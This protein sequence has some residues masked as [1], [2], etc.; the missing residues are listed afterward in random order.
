MLST[1]PY[2]KAAARPLLPELT[3]LFREGHP[4]FSFSSLS[5]KVRWKTAE[6]N[7]SP[8]PKQAFYRPEALQE[9]FGE[10]SSYPERK[11]LGLDLGHTLISN[12]FPAWNA[13]IQFPFIKRN[14]PR[15]TLREGRGR[16]EEMGAPSEQF[17]PI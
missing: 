12:H 2:R 1:P 6:S 5:F 14:E 11:E 16:M 7:P 15:L 3:S 10:T 17:S 9:P 13:V 8:G 4:G